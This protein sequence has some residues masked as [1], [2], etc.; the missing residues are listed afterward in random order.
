[1]VDRP[2]FDD[3]TLEFDYWTRV[4][5]VELNRGRGHFVTALGEAWYRAD[6]E[7]KRSLLPAVREIADRHFLMTNEDRVKNRI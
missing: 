7:N 1:M 6:L 5:N 4:F 2:K 3:E